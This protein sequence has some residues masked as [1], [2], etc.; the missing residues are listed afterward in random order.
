[1]AL[2]PAPT[3]VHT[4][5]MVVATG[6]GGQSVGRVQNLQGGLLNSAAAKTASSI[7]AQAGHARAAGVTMKG[8][9]QPI[10]VPEVAEGGTI[11]GV[12]FAGNHA[13]LHGTLNQLNADKTYDNLAGATPYKVGGRRRY[14]RIPN[15]RER[16]DE[17]VYS[18]GR[19]HK[20][21]TKRKH[22]RSNKRSS[23]RRVRKHHNRTRRNSH[24]RKR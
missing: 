8:G 21:K 19:K 6:L 18:A 2:S 20:R 4:N 12:S 3:T 11:P 13:A 1:M 14:H 22:G 5:G 15:A 10:H 16:I 9:G 23:H 7:A 17:P 24:G